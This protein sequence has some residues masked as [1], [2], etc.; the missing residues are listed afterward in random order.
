MFE[1][2]ICLVKGHRFRKRK[3]ASRDSV[4]VCD[5]CGKQ[6]SCKKSYLPEEGC[7]CYWEWTRQGPAHVEVITCGEDSGMVTLNEP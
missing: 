2:M 3:R 6:T 5:R 7:T 1:K 4:C